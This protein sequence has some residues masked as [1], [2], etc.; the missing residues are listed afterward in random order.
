MT[1]FTET[2]VGGST[3]GPMRCNSVI[4]GLKDESTSGRLVET[5]LENVDRL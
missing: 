1:H 3:D 2:G 4:R 5:E